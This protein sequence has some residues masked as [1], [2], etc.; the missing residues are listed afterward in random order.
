MKNTKIYY[1]HVINYYN[2]NKADWRNVLSKLNT[3]VVRSREEDHIPVYFTKYRVKSPQ[4]I[5]LKIKRN[6]EITLEEIDDYA[7]LRVVCLFEDELFDINK[8]IITM[9]RSLN[10]KLKEVEIYGWDENDH[11]VQR[12]KSCIDLPADNISIL[13]KM[14]GY[15]SVHYLVTDSSNSINAEIQLRTLLQ[16]VWA[17]IE[18]TVSYKK[19]N[20]HPH[21]K[22]SFSLLA[23]ELNAKDITLNFLKKIRDKESKIEL[24]SNQKVGIQP[25]FCYEDDIRPKLFLTKNEVKIAVHLYEKH[26]RS[27]GMKPEDSNWYDTAI[28]LFKK[29]CALLPQEIVA[30]LPESKPR[31]EANDI[32]LIYWFR[33][34]KAYLSFCA[35]KVKDALGIYNKLCKSKDYSGRD[36]MY[37]IYFRLGEINFLI[38]NIENALINFDKAEE[39]I[40]DLKQCH[41]SNEN[42]YKIYK[43]IARVYLLLDDQYVDV[44]LEKINEAK[45]IPLSPSFKNGRKMH[46]LNLECYASLSKFITNWAKENNNKQYLYNRDEH[47]KTAEELYSELIN[48]INNKPDVNGEI[49]SNIYDTL[50]WFCYQKYL[51]TG[52]IKVLEEAKKY[53]E[54]M[55]NRRNEHD[56]QLT[57]INTHRNHFET[58]MGTKTD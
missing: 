13:K 39:L 51:V 32:N 11:N 29:V 33:M 3:E 55:L 47:F 40:T 9:L 54:E 8:Y 42:R 28:E 20:I 10:C 56:F 15:R 25:Y 49:S 53:C 16:D 23:Y 24:F 21:I 43:K 30:N 58:I 19:G 18:H 14:S 35:G 1:S 2:Q 7:G 36:M 34:E 37:V 57:S 38:G 4:S 22:E 50:A 5:F 12:I 44:V 26:V 46:L 45:K 52:N 27:Y 6:T 17:E 31:E 48:I 41:C